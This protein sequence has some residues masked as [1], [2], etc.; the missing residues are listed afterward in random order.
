MQNPT[1][2]V[3]AGVLLSCETAEEQ[4]AY[5]RSVEAGM[6]SLQVERRLN[7]RPGVTAD[8]VRTEMMSQ[9]TISRALGETSRTLEA[10]RRAVRALADTRAELARL[11]SVV[12]V[13]VRSLACLIYLPVLVTGAG[14][15]SW[16]GSA[17]SLWG[18]LAIFSGLIFVGS[19]MVIPAFLNPR[20]GENL[21]NQGNLILHILLGLPACLLDARRARR[22]WEND[23]HD[24]TQR[25]ALLVIE[26]LM[27]TD[28]HSV[29][30]PGSFD[31][32]RSATG[33][34]WV[35]ANDASRQLERKLSI[36]EGGTIAVCGPRGVG[37]TTL[38]QTAARNQDFVVTIRVPA[39]YTPSDLVLSTF[40][41]VCERFIR[42]E[43]HEPP[44][45]TRLSGFIRVRRRVRHALRNLRRRIFFG[46]PAAALITLGTAAAARTLWDKHSTDLWSWA[47]T[48]RHWGIVQAEDIWRG[49]SIGGGLV[50]T[51]AGL[52]VWRARKAARLRRR[53]L[54]APAALVRLVAACLLFGPVVSLP[55]DPD[56]RRHFLSL[57]EA[58]GS[59]LLYMLLLCLSL[60]LLIGGAV[61]AQRSSTAATIR[62]PW[63]LGAACSLIAA[64]FVFLRDAEVQAILRDAENPA[65]LTYFVAGVLLLRVGS[66]KSRPAEP[67][68]VTRCRN[69]L[70]Q[71]RT[72][73]STSATLNLG[74]TQAAT[75]IGSA[76]SSALASIPPN[77][78]QMVEDLRSLLADI[79]PHV[80]R[81]G[82][83][84]IICFDELDRLGTDKQALLFLSEIKAILGVP[85]VHYLISVAEDVGA[86]FVRRGLPHR[87][88]TD[89]SLDDVVHVQPCSLADSVAIMC[90]RA[91]DLTPPYVLLAH[92]LSG[93]IPRDL[94]RYGRRILEMHED[95]SSARQAPAVEL[96]DISRRIILEELSD[97]LSGF[98][99]L[100]AKQQWTYEN[101]GWL[102]N[103]RILMDHLRHAC[104]HRT[105]DLVAAL[106]YISSRTLPSSGAVGEPPEE[107]RQLIAEAS[108]YTYYT[109]TLLQIFQPDDFEGRRIRAADSAAGDPQFLAEARLELTVSPHS[110]RPL[111]DEV[112][113]AWHLSSMNAGPS[114]ASIPAPRP[115][116]CLSPTCT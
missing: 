79:A 73:Q 112:R 84:T 12:R 101:A 2:Q 43:G 39:A 53:L 36:L 65:R 9:D 87:D 37:K 30:L 29:L 106:E 58:T 15:I 102:A 103:Y 81:R 26:A 50:V 69:H 111:I 45:F 23:L 88:A 94:I 47:N 68:L 46:V 16:P 19:V 114:F 32:L 38:L 98:R 72:A 1:P 108:V 42:R 3:T 78:P 20:S 115:Q 41:K 83:R 4:A 40:V 11:R 97:T 96:T 75:T 59:L 7:A 63:K 5:T 70:Y 18:E 48:V 104:P 90:K 13:D 54:A 22:R 110:A 62:P 25:V 89:S 100:L 34:G 61:R 76:H 93:G 21:H 55:F 77:F 14:Y 51:V 27:G 99:T 49:H 33:A 60:V 85:H 74:L 95:I 82:G 113:M 64:L 28:P 91:T 71:L 86:A 17:L 52:L 56:V 31:G 105:N 107:A 67:K 116:P 92:A 24:G 8:A 109:L 80:H 44:D 10:Y 35:V 57:G 6:A 66:W